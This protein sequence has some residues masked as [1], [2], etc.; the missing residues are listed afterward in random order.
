MKMMLTLIGLICSFAMQAAEP[1]VK[2]GKTWH[3]DK[4]YAMFDDEISE[5]DKKYSGTCSFTDSIVRNGH[6]YYRFEWDNG[7][8]TII[9]LRQDGEKVYRYWDTTDEE[10]IAKTGGEILLY[11]FS[12]KEGDV[13]QTYY[14]QSFEEMYYVYPLD[15]YVN[16]AGT[17]MIKGHERKYQYLATYGWSPF[18]PNDLPREGSGL[19]VI[20]GIGPRRGFISEP[21]EFWPYD[22]GVRLVYYTTKVCDGDEVI[23]T[24]DDFKLFTAGVEE[25]LDG[26]CVKD[27]KMYD[28]MGREV[29]NPQPGSVY[30]RNGRKFVAR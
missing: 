9:Y 14:S 5:S 18:D 23:F 25:V 16:S 10:I 21:F 11:D 29:K 3:Y 22:G 20:E 28:I 1:M 30:I 12:L 27:G 15:M 13:Y 8:P 4:T 17:V 7:D 24:G 26:G 6:T 19:L 2:L